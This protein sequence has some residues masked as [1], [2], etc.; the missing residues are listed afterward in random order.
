MGLSRDTVG[1]LKGYRTVW[2]YHG[3][4][5]GLQDCLEVPW[6]S[7][8]TTRLSGDTMKLFNGY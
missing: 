8:R 5:E 4:T 2:G 7:R 6:D 3:V 1:F